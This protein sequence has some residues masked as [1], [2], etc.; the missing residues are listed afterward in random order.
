MVGT[1]SLRLV[2]PSALL[3]LGPLPA[4]DAAP[5]TAVV[6]GRVLDSLGEPIVQATVRA[7]RSS[8]D[9]ELATQKTDGSGCFLLSGV[10]LDEI[11]IVRAEAAGHTHDQTWL[12]P[13][14]SREALPEDLVLHDAGTVTGV[15]VDAKGAPVPG[16]CVSVATPFGRPRAALVEATTDAQGRFTIEAAPLG[17]LLVLTWKRGFVLDER[18]LSLRDRSEPR[19]EL[20]D[21]GGASLEVGVEGLAAADRG[22]VR[23]RLERFVDN[24]SQELPSPLGLCVLDERGKASV[25]GLLP[26]KYQ[27]IPVSRSVSVRV[28]ANEAATTPRIPGMQRTPARDANLTL[29][30]GQRQ[31]VTFE[32]A[33]PQSVSIVGTLRAEDGTA[34]GGRSLRF[35]TSNGVRI[36]TVRCDAAGAFAVRASLSQGERLWPQLLDE[37]L[38]LVAAPGDGNGHVV[39]GARLALEMSAR[40]PAMVRGKVLAADGAALAGVRVTMT[41]LLLG[42]GNSISLAPERHAWASSR[43]GPDGTF[44]LRWD[45]DRTTRLGE[46][47][48]EASDVQGCAVAPLDDATA[49]QVLRLQPAARLEGVVRDALGQPIGGMRLRLTRFDEVAIG[50]GRPG[51]INVVTTRDGRYRMATSAGTYRLELFAGGNTA[52]ATRAP[53]TIAPGEQQRG[54]DL[55]LSK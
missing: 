15:V 50:G 36:G 19:I 28:R 29:G 37:E 20:V 44:V 52:V 35:S 12:W 42:H 7:S 39:D 1:R 22:S 47:R 24:W 53:I 33:K 13:G 6:T 54:V 40:P 26:G 16:A 4:Q 34:L 11:V 55:E 5:A 46:R 18:Q 3:V 23:L 9:R 32:A 41:A 17:E 43:S 8:D 14:R 21:H 38:F 30:A 49:T 10:P 25:E 45:D 2:I 48:I 51:G 27:M 31:Q